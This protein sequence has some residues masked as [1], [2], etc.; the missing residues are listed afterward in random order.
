MSLMAFLFVVVVVV[1]G[2]FV[3]FAVVSEKG[4]T[5]LSCPLLHIIRCACMISVIKC[6]VNSK[7]QMPDCNIYFW[8]QRLCL[9][10]FVG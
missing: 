3:L 2:L 5:L 7:H 4:G 10:Y 6:P 1:V 8:C 9:A